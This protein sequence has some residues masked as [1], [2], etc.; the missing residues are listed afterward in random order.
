MEYTKEGMDELLTLRLEAADLSNVKTI[1][2]N[3]V[4]DGSKEIS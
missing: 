3:Y 1:M 4:Y 2:S